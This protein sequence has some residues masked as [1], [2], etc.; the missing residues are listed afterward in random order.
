[1][2][3]RKPIKSP[4]EKGGLHPRNRHQG[5]YDFDQLTRCLPE[6]KQF[7]MKTPVGE[8]TIDFANPLAVKAL[9]RALLKQFYGISDWDIPEG[10]L[11]PPI[12]GRADYIH[13]VADLI[14]SDQVKPI[15]VL[16]IGVGANCV[17][18][19]IGSREYGWNFVGTDVDAGALA[20][21]KRIADA[22]PHL[23]A[24]LELRQQKS[25]S[26][27]LLGIIESDEKFDLS[28][29]N[30]PFHSSLEE[31]RLGTQRKWKN[32]GR[33]PRGE[34]SRIKPVVKNFGGQGSEL[35][36]PGGEA[37]FI[38]KMID[39]SAQFKNHVRWFTSLVSKSAHLDQI[40]K[41]LK[42]VRAVEVREQQMS[43]GQKIS[44]IIAWTFQRSE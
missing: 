35:W 7:V 21:A 42:R 11:C 25:K 37:E 17:Y 38:G 1:M 14:M 36:C 18:P 9:N 29:C 6:L 33:Q 26:Q 19:I 27:I 41:D 30:P 34:A 23:K 20:S 28:I 43:Q 32:L 13:H 31:A 10:Y 22:N 15:R 44:R 16:D 24:V 39:E 4:T 2:R 3:D 40:Y 8:P 12:P 5:R